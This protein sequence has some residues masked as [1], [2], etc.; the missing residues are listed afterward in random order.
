MTHESA[1]HNVRLVPRFTEQERAL[2]AKNMGNILMVSAYDDA[3]VINPH[4]EA[5][6]ANNVYTVHVNEGL[7][8]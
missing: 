1:E 6:Q 3:V 5:A 7:H 2:L 8:S 4:H